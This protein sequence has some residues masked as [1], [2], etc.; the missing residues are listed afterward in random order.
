M[1]TVLKLHLGDAIPFLVKIFERAIEGPAEGTAYTRYYILETARVTWKEVATEL[2]KVMYEK[3]IFASSEP[4]QVPMEEAGN[5]E[6][7]H[8]IAANML[9]KGERAARMGFSATH[10]SILVQMHKDLKE[11]RL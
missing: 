2:A 10:P 1:L 8:L 6:V 11:A 7:K 5:G 3:G 4:K 9:V